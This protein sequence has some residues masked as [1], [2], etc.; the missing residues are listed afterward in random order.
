MFRSFNNLLEKFHQSFFLYIL[1]VQNRYISIGMYMPP[2]GLILAPLLI[3]LLTLWMDLIA[4]DEVDIKVISSS[5]E[6]EG[7]V[8][9]TSHGDDRN[10][11]TVKAREFKGLSDANFHFEV[12]ANLA[13]FCTDLF[14]VCSCCICF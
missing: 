11:E 14:H 7:S 5:K 13:L 12:Y 1:P 8:S 9:T 2:L 10:C 3:S 4:C 6:V